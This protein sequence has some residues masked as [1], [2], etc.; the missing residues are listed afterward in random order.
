MFL[1]HVSARWY[2]SPRISELFEGCG[3]LNRSANDVDMSAVDRGR[4]NGL[5]MCV[6]GLMRCGCSCW[7]VRVMGFVLREIVMCLC[8]VLRL[9]LMS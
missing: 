6:C 7:Y 1:E 5:S 2:R 4:V 9:C 8:N 3:C